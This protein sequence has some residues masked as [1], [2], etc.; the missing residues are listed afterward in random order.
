MSASKLHKIWNHP[1]GPKTIHFWAP[2]FKWGIN[3]A[4]I[5]DSAKPPEQ[6]SYPQ[7]SAL[8]CSAIIWARYS[9]VVTPKNWNLCSVSVVMAATS[10][11]QLARKLEHDFLSNEKAAAAKK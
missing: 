6:L 2:T 4:N 1:A 3:I 8:A 11:F 5:F 10:I 7:Q 9:T